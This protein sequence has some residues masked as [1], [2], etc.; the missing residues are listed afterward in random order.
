M[1]LKACPFCG[2]RACQQLERDVVAGDGST[3]FAVTC[4]QPRCGL[5]PVRESIANAKNA[6]N[7][8]S[9]KSKANA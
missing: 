3:G 1:R 8:R 9:T 5:G 2:K 7:T 4:V 6:W